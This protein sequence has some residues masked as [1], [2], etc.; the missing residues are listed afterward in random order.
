[1]P[2]YRMFPVG[3]HPDRA[4]DDTEEPVTDDDEALVSMAQAQS[5]SE[6]GVGPLMTLQDLERSLS[7][8]TSTPRGQFRRSSSGMHISKKPINDGMP[9]GRRA[10]VAPSVK[11]VS[12]EPEEKPAQAARDGASGGGGGGGGNGSNRGTASRGG[13]T[14]QAG[15]FESLDG[16][17]GNA[18]GPNPNDGIGGGHAGD[19]DE[20]DSHSSASTTSSHAYRKSQRGGRKFRTRLHQPASN[21]DG[22]TEHA[23]GTVDADDGAD[24]EPRAA[25]RVAN[26]AALW[27]RYIKPLKPHDRPPV[28][29]AVV[30]HAPGIRVRHRSLRSVLES[31]PKYDQETG[32]LIMWMPVLRQ[33]IECVTGVSDLVGHA[34]CGLPAA[35]SC[36]PHDPQSAA[37]MGSAADHRSTHG[38]RVDTTRL[39]R[40]PGVADGKTVTAGP[41]THKVNL[42]MLHGPPRYR[43]QISINNKGINA[44]R[45]PLITR[46]PALASIM[47]GGID[48]SAA[49]ADQLPTAPPSPDTMRL[50]SH[51]IPNAIRATSQ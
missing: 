4:A 11:Q 30:R 28:E 34:H 23:R 25:G 32:A 38:A 40:L 17:P 24:S 47:S 46:I 20:V 33:P 22:D 39:P 51:M 50:S 6:G 19:V 9:A 31:L 49:P 18:G 48:G 36:V 26:R 43:R 8:S 3:Q 1:M 45:L 27:H 15:A 29:V 14:L 37:S 5:S 21:H 41:W 2:K 7:L 35:E 44:V 16:Q 10:S 13:D 12:E 42:D